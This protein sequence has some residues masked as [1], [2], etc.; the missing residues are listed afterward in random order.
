VNTEVRSTAELKAIGEGIEWIN[1]R[2]KIRVD[3][4]N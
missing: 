4:K 3:E 1:E 2:K